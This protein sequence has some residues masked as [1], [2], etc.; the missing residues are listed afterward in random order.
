MI[1]NKLSL[2]VIGIYVFLGQLFAQA[3]TAVQLD[4]LQ[5][6]SSPAF[7]LLGVAP[8]SIERPKNPTDFSFALANATN[9]FTALPKNFSLE[10][11]PFW[12][13]SK[14]KPSLQSF[15]SEKPKYSIP[16]TLVL[17]VGT[18]TSRSSFDSSEFT[19]VAVG[20]SLS[21]LRGK[22][23][24]EYERWS[25][26]LS[27]ILKRENQKAEYWY[28]LYEKN[29]SL[30][31]LLTKKIGDSTITDIARIQALED[32]ANVIQKVLHKQAEKAYQYDLIKR[33]EDLANIKR[34]AGSTD[35]KRY[36]FKL[37]MAGGVVMDYPANTFQQAYLSKAGAWLTM[38]LEDKPNE[39]NF[40]ALVRFTGQ[41]DYA[42]KNQMGMKVSNLHHNAF[43]IGF[44]LYKD[45]NDKFTLSYELIRRLVSYNNQKFEA[46]NVIPPDN[47]NRSAFSINYKIGKNQNLSFSFGKDF[48]QPFLQKDNL[49]TSLSFLS[50][51]GS[52]RPIGSLK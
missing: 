43:D 49:I 3:D 11:A 51:L 28:R 20:F 47:S 35:F 13:F 50:G 41:F 32:S 16:Q 38:G 33:A 25:D 46:S 34:L 18:N 8:N 24:E 15:I 12:L 44:R 17:S 48:L 37:D 4:Q 39:L 1:Y 52:L 40:L 27:K 36:G 2:T 45:F 30:F 14:K 19:Q 29:D 42:L 10:V 6:P 22:V 31:Q 9:G 5:V 23:A 26:T 21:I 7:V